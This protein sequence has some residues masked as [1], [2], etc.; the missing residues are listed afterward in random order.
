M[1]QESR[2]EKKLDEKLD[3]VSDA[4]NELNKKFS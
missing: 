3:R 2:Q 4:F 1:S